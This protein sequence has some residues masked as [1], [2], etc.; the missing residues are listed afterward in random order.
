MTISEC[1]GLADDTDITVFKGGTCSRGVRGRVGGELGQCLVSTSR[2]HGQTHVHA[3]FR[4]TLV[5]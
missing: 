5:Q 3:T 4:V 2:S 1:G